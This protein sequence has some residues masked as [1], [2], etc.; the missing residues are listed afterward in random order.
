MNIQTNRALLHSPLDLHSKTIHF[1]KPGDSETYRIHN[2]SGHNTWDFKLSM[3]KIKG[4]TYDAAIISY[5]WE[6]KL[7]TGRNR[8]P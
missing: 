8:L 4:N 6:V 7:E 3:T 2:F 1:F 5:T